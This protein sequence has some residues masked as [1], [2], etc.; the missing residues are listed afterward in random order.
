MRS[1]NSGAS[2]LG[3]FTDAR[4]RIAEMVRAAPNDTLAVR[5]QE[6][7]M[8]FDQALA[9]LREHLEAKEAEEKEPVPAP[10]AEAEE[11]VAAPAGAMEALTRRFTADEASLRDFY[12]E[13]LSELR[14]E[15]LRRADAIVIGGAHQ[16]LA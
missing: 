10:E 11:P 12:G 4:E 9:A 2:H 8:E 7:L 15:R 6:G 3:E 14:L 16:C 13:P 1:K 5:Y